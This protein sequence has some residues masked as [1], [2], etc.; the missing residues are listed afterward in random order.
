MLFACLMVI[1]S[2][3][4]YK[5]IQRI[6][7]VRTQ[8]RNQIRAMKKKDFQLLRCLFAQDIVF[9]IFKFWIYGLYVYEAVTKDQ[10]QPPLELAVI[11]FLDRFFV[12]LY[13]VSY[14]VN[15]VIFISISKAFRQEVKR[16]VWKMIGKDLASF[17]E[18]DN[19]QETAEMNVVVVSH[20]VTQL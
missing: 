2:V 4:A 10:I 7:T 9:I 18:E 5:N 11:T 13:N 1:L 6:R 16:M 14:T 8:Q 15:F 3:I 20:I 19:R 12:F 17:R